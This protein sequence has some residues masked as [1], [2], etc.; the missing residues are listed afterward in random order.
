VVNPKLI[1]HLEQI[2]LTDKSALV[3]AYLLESGGSFP[4]IISQKTKLNRSTVYK[5][6]DDLKEKNLIVESEKTKKLYYKVLDP[7]RL[8][9]FTKNNI[10]TATDRHESAERLLPRLLDLFSST[11]ERPKINF[12]GGPNTLPEL[13]HDAVHET[14]DGVI[15]IFGNQ[16]IFAKYL[17]K[18]ELVEIIKEK[19]KN[20]IETRE[21][22]PDTESNR[23]Y[24]DQTFILAKKSLTPKVRFVP[25]DLYAFG[26]MVVI[27]GI[28]KIAIIKPTQNNLSCTIIDDENIQKT[29]KMIFEICW[30][31]GVE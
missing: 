7:D 8:L 13:Y 18:D 30:N 17:A 10:E 5:I 3:Y 14:G 2:G 29:L 27:F 23:N 21:I 12:L 11:E 25:K 26:S 24:Y 1:K 22:L 19:E 6:L 9:K 20:N 15:R 31:E 28:S 16:D 4:S